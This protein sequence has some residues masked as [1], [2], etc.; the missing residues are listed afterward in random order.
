VDWFDAYAYAKW[1]GRRLPTE[2]EWEKAARGQRGSKHPWGNEDS[3]KMAN[4]E[5][6]F[7]PNPD[8]KAGGNEDGFKRSSPVNKPSTDVSDYGVYNMG[9]NVSEWTSTWADDSAG[10]GFK[11]PVYRGSNWNSRPKD[12]SPTDT[13]MRRGTNHL[14]VESADYLG[15]RTASDTP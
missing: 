12:L 6:D 15:F 11:V 10:S 7:T 4:L 13:V 3:I 9:G 8:A 14:D 2:E 1:K 5:F